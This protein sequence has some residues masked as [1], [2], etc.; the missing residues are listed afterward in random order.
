[1]RI[2]LMS[3][4]SGWIFFL[5]L[6]ACSPVFINKRHTQAFA[7]PEGKLHH[8]IYLIGDVGGAEEEPLSPALTLLKS[9]LENETE[10]A[11]VVFLGDNVYPAGLPDTND[12]YRAKAESILRAQIKAVKDHPGQIVFI[13]GNHDW[14]RWRLGGKEAVIRQQTFISDY[15][16]RNDVFYPQ[17]ACGD[18]VV[19]ELEEN[20]ALLLIDS[21]WFLHDWQ[22][23][24]DQNA[25]CEIQ[26]R[27]EFKER[28][29][30]LVD[31]YDDRHLLIAF[32]HPLIT[33]GP[34][35][36]YFDYRAHLFPLSQINHNLF[37][38]LPGLGTLTTWIR[39]MGLSPQDD[40]HPRFRAFS[41]IM[42]DATYKKGNILF[43]SGH[44]H[45]LQYAKDPG[46]L[47]DR[48]FIVSGSGSERSTLRR[49]D[50]IA[51]GYVNHGHARLQYY[52]D[53]TV[54]LEMWRPIADGQKGEMLYRTR[55]KAPNFSVDPLD[56]IE[57]LADTSPVTVVADTIYEA[58][59]TQKKLLGTLY[60][61]AW[62]TPLQFP[63]L[64][65]ATARGG[66]RPIKK[67][68]G[69]QTLSLRLA[70]Q[71]GQ[72]FVLRSVHKD[73]TK[74]AQ[75]IWPDFPARSI[76]GD[77]VQDQ[78][79][80]SHP[81]A[82][83]VV[84][85]LA[86]AVGVLHTNPRF[87]YLPRQRGLGDFSDD[88][89]GQV[90]LFEERPHKSQKALASFG[91]P[92]KIVSTRKMLRELRE[93][94]KHLVDQEAVLRARLLDMLLG[95]W[96]RHD[97]QWRWA[98]FG[99]AGWKKYRPIPRDRD[100]VFSVV[101]GF[102]P[103]LVTSVFGL[104]FLHNF[105]ENTKDLEGLNDHARFFDRTF[106]TELDRTDW[107]RISREM[108]G[109]LTDSLLEAALRLWPD[110]L[111]ALNGQHILPIL[112]A[113][114]DNLHDMAMRY[115]P[116][117]AHTVEILGS[118]KRDRFDVIRQEKDEVRII[119]RRINKVGEAKDTL[120]DRHFYLSETKEIRLYG[121][122]HDDQFVLSGTAEKGSMIRIVGGG[123]METFDDQSRLADGR[124]TF[125]Y[126]QPQDSL[127]HF[128]EGTRDRTRDIESI[129][130]YQRESYRHNKSGPSAQIS[131]NVDDGLFLGLGFKKEIHGFR[132]EP[133][134]E[135]QSLMLNYAAATNNLTLRYDA[136]FTDVL[137]RF[138]LYL[139]A[140]GR[141][142]S[143]TIN[144]FGLGNET[145]K[146]REQEFDFNRLRLRNIHLESSLQLLE[147]EGMHLLR[148]GPFYDYFQAEESMDRFVGLD[149]SRVGADF[150]GKHFAGLGI[151]YKGDATDN[152]SM[153]KRGIRFNFALRWQANLADLNRNFST[154][155]LSF[156][157]FR[158]VLQ[159]LD[160]VLASRFGFS[161]NFGTYEF[162]QARQLGGRTNLR[163]FRSERFAGDAALFHNTELRFRLFRIKNYYLPLDIG[164]V[165]FF[166]YG[167][168]WLADEN[169]NRLHNG[170]GAGLSISPYSVGVLNVY[171]SRSEDLQAIMVR[172]GHY[173]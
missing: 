97:D 146:D 65:L 99:D 95:D 43:A 31:E 59:K 156:S 53:G 84:P 165:L 19:L 94:N 168:V 51:F 107:D 103:K 40:Q 105:S 62:Q 171:L 67:G 128:G 8:S 7:P 86:D 173:F 141:N 18:P 138:D 22:Q 2:S 125:F 98:E 90:F 63:V 37:I 124:R 113:R 48:H 131:Y 133:F 20:I 108:Q 82:A 10:N 24:D 75:F 26:S 117:L 69:Y 47:S 64:D 68:G 35:G 60:R 88:F 152:K 161:R 11:S 55:L 148:M 57:P 1:M 135:Q 121:F 126:D 92:D 4:I 45:S 38:P 145:S 115:Y 140:R 153:P 46:V 166:D 54:W 28:V 104:N 71:T 44:E 101:N 56:Q 41:D 137:G 150:E 6:S 13:P 78:I 32:H 112:K 89:G 27:D 139:H 129:N 102:I 87:V 122:Q 155:N 106:L 110:T 134:Q 25:G 77:F 144:Y 16:Q 9:Q 116:Q 50:R 70:S 34:H 66:L 33:N 136:T 160:V 83:R 142:P 30:E 23:R 169:S 159:P 91:K 158:Q 5:L 167:R 120:Y 58:T 17:N 172:F 118:N 111:Y 39:Q 143:N 49:N 85:P 147:N 151:S 127:I 76:L 81:Y 149:S 42:M 14:N 79:A 170:Y 36:G 3:L 74:A 114:R 157:F 93:D 73:A 132:K 21:Q 29:F 61:D 12:V 96:D 130:S 72:Q 109:Q 154:L 119:L 15:L 123:G 80:M 163:G 100:Q 164:A 162:Y 52:E